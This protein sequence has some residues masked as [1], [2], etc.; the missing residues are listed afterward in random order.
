M[1][2]RYSKCTHFM[3]AFSNVLRG[4]LN[5]MGTGIIIL[6]TNLSIDCDTTNTVFLRY[7]NSLGAG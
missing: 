6:T 5:G 2:S 4:Y 1:T 7:L 3:N